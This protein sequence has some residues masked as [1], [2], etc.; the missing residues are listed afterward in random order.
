MPEHPSNDGLNIAFSSL[1]DVIA[2]MNI[3][4]RNEY[5]SLEARSAVLGKF[6]HPEQPYERARAEMH[7]VSV[8][9][10]ETCGSGRDSLIYHH[11]T[12][13]TTGEVDDMFNKLQR[14]YRRTEQALNHMKADLRKKLEARHLEETQKRQEAACEYKKRLDEYNLIYREIFIKYEQ[15]QKEEQVRLSKIKLAIPEALVSTVDKLNHLAD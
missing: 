14:E 13:I 6:I 7:M 11:E 10:Y 5:L 3:K 4:E 12:S 9:P 2:E 15:W 8:K 1:D